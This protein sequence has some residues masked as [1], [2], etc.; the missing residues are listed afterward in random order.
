MALGEV[1]DCDYR[2]PATPGTSRTLPVTR[3]RTAL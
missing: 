2:E 3:D 1:E